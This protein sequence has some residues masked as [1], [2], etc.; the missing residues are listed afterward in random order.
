MDIEL[1]TE[2][3][4]VFDLLEKTDEHYFVTGRAGT[5]KSLLL[6]YFKKNSLKKAVVVAP[7]G[8]A[9]LNVGGQTIHSFFRIPPSFVDKHS[10]EPDDKLNKLLQ[11][12]ETI[13]IDEI[14]MVRADLMDAIDHR[15]R[16]ARGE[17]FPFGGVQIVMFGDLFQL[18]PV[19]TDDDLKQY[20]E[21]HYGGHY[22][23]NAHVWNQADLKVVELKEIFRQKDEGFRQILNAIRDGNIDEQILSKLNI[24]ATMPIPED[25]IVTLSTTNKSVNKINNYFLSQLDNTVYEYKAEISGRLE[26]SAFPTEEV[27][28][29]KKGAQVIFLKND[30]EKRWVNGTLGTVHSLSEKSIEVRTGGETHSVTPE[31][32]EKIKYSV[33]R[34]TGEVEEEVVSQFKQYPLRL[35]WALTIH[36][37]QGQTLESVIIDMGYGAF[38]FGQTY[39]ALSRATN[40]DNLYLK[41]E[42]RK[43]DIMVDPKIVEFMRGKK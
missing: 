18:P 30:K 37:S 17:M 38:A 9:A 6:K 5:G 12:V 20:F 34:Q 19:V 42:V 3:Q 7:T 39:V 32:W 24:R 36:K 21:I 29:F 11:S 27:L 1:S 14:S 16:Q 26:P 10:L 13:V 28:N 31:I 35:A 41:R 8:V 40:L 4:Q 23:F 33:N 22:F 43:E 15:L 25:P 2:Q